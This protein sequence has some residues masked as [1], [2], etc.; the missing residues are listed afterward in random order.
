MNNY[1]NNKGDSREIKTDIVSNENYVKM[2]DKEL[3]HRKLGQV[4]FNYLNLIC[5][6]KLLEG[7]PD[8]IDSEYVKCTTCIKSKM[9]KLPLENKRKRA[10]QILEI[11]HTDI[12]GPH[13][14]LG[15]NGEKYFLTFIDDFNK[16]A[17]IYCIKSKSEVAN[18]LK[19]YVNLIENLTEKR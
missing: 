17:T 2:S 6:N 13:T 11:I 14:T 12:N 8:K 10:N 15:N 19:D 5:T 3:W 18:C 4:Y 1:I 7:I 16:L 9:H